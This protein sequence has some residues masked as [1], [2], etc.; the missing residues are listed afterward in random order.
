[1]FITDFAY[2]EVHNVERLIFSSTNF[3]LSACDHM[4]ISE[5]ILAKWKII[6]WITLLVRIIAREDVGWSISDSNQLITTTTAILTRQIMAGGVASPWKKGRQLETKH[7]LITRA[8]CIGICGWAESTPLSCNHVSAVSTIIGQTNWCS[9][10]YIIGL[11]CNRA[12]FQ[13]IFTR[14]NLLYLP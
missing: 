5:I 1:M 14:Q 12:R 8:V 4:A 6:L 2:A 7:V 11:Y 9:S 3:N 10:R 13:G